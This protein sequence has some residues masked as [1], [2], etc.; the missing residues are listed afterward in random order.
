MDDQLLFMRV[1]KALVTIQ[2]EKELTKRAEARIQAIV[3]IVSL[4]MDVLKRVIDHTF[5][6]RMAVIK[7]IGKQAETIKDP[8]HSVAIIKVMTDYSRSSPN[9]TIKEAANIIAASISEHRIPP[10]ALEPHFLPP[11]SSDQG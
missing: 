5:T 7:L 6:E 8:E 11:A 1:V 2:R 10:A 9:Q 4:Q 3:Q